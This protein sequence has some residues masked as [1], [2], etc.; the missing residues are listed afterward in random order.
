MAASS[1]RTP[2]ARS[3]GEIIIR[4]LG[5]HHG[6]EAIERVARRDDLQQ[7]TRVASVTFEEVRAHLGVE[8][9]RQWSDLAIARTTP[10]LLG[11]FSLVAL[12]MDDLVKAKRIAPQA[13]AWYRK[14][15]LTFIDAIAATRREIWLHQTSSISR[16]SPDGVKIPAHIWSRMETAVAHAR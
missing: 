10:A 15:R 4:R 2:N 3:R 7:P 1:S 12:W 6:P 13:T 9:Q 11:L 16:S 14:T 8:T 5:R